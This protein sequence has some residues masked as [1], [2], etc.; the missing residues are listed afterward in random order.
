MRRAPQPGQNPARDGQP[1]EDFRLSAILYKQLMRIGPRRLSRDAGL[2]HQQLITSGHAAWLLEDDIPPV[3]GAA[4]LDDTARTVHRVRVLLNPSPL[5]IPDECMRCFLAGVTTLFP[6][7][8][9]MK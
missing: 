7:L 9:S 8:R 6:Q 5:T 4:P 2:V 1:P 3:T